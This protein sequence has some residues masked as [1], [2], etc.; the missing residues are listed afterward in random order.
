MGSDNYIEVL[1]I[2]DTVF[3]QALSELSSSGFF[4]DIAIQCFELVEILF[5]ASEHRFNFLMLG[6]IASGV[7]I[8]SLGIVDW[9]FSIFYCGDSAGFHHGH[10]A[11]QNALLHV[12]WIELE[13]LLFCLDFGFHETPAVEHTQIQ[14]SPAIAFLED[15][16]DLLEVGNGDSVKH[17]RIAGIGTDPLPHLQ[18]EHVLW[19]IESVNRVLIELYGA[20]VKLTDRW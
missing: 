19:S 2:Y 5:H 20:A 17:R 8:L 18:E 1:R 6:G 3:D 12:L 15:D 10:I 9:C 16:V 7:F 13:L 4:W 14:D 11:A